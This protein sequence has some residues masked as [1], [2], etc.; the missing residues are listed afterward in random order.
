MNYQIISD[1]CAIIERFSVP[2]QTRGQVDTFL[3]WQATLSI[4]Q[5]FERLEIHLSMADEYLLF[6]TCPFK[7]LKCSK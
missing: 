7:Y 5:T 3:L 4:T 1:K 6:L 2:L